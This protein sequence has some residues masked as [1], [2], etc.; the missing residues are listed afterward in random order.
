MDISARSAVVVRGRR[1]RVA[2]WSVVAWTMLATSIGLSPGLINHSLMP[3]GQAVAIK[4]VAVACGL[5]MYFSLGSKHRSCCRID[6]RG[7]T[8]RK[9]RRRHLRWE[10]IDA[11]YFGGDVLLLRSGEF[12]IG[13]ARR[14][15]DPPEWQFLYRALR[16]LLSPE[17]GAQSTDAERRWAR[18]ANWRWPRKALDRLLCVG[19]ALLI[20]GLMLLLLL[21]MRAIGTGAG[22]VVGISIVALQ[23]WASGRYAASRER[24]MNQQWR[25]RN[26]V[27]HTPCNVAHSHLMG[28]ILAGN[29]A[30][31]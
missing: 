27:C 17:F 5:F 4:C 25:K 16:D 14:D 6:S 2:A 28:P 26:S 22:V 13:V 21:L 23:L 19:V 12:T 18:M 9:C 30:G 3:L 29:L 24:W 10:A 11:V 31:C 15:F 20:F 8:V 1:Q 7:V